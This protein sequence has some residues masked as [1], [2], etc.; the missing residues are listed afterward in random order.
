M[1]VF[2]VSLSSSSSSSPFSSSLSLS[3]DISLPR[4]IYFSSYSPVSIQQPPLPL[5][6]RQ[7][8]SPSSSSSISSL[9]PNRRTSSSLSPSSSS[10]SLSPSSSCR[11]LTSF[12]QN[13][14]QNVPTSSSSLCECVSPSHHPLPWISTEILRRK[15]K[16]KSS[17]ELSY[18]N[19]QEGEVKHSRKSSSSPCSLFSSLS[20]FTDNF[21]P[22]SSSSSSLW[23]TRVNPIK[24]HSPA[25]KFSNA[26]LS[27]TSFVSSSSSYSCSFSAL[28]SLAVSSSFPFPDRFFSP[29][30]L[31][32]SQN[33]CMG[34]VRTVGILASVTAGQ[35]TTREYEEAFLPRRLKRIKVF[36]TPP[37]RDLPA[38]FHKLLDKAHSNPRSI[39]KLYRKYIKID[40]HPDY[41]WLVRCFCQLANTFGFNSFWA[42]KDKQVVHSIPS[43]KFLVYD[44]IE[45]KHLIQASEVPRLLYALAAIEYRS[46]HLLPTLLEHV[47]ANLHRW[48][49]P[50]LC[51]MALSL[52][53]M[54]VGDNQT[55]EQR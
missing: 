33:W 13:V 17:R 14:F 9:K 31:H 8:V 52:A 21:S 53:L 32:A 48:R 44:L 29:P 24:L 19:F 27:S 43:F 37:P 41:S 5:P 34:G 30:S 12:S 23:Y 20:W 3:R 49:A 39:L 45:R 15:Q 1:K 26:S 2:F 50:T 4:R 40:D 46:W 7:V 55:G 36:N 6:R 47:D 10:S 51:N 25:V 35:M 16:K 22:L 18:F 11:L 28:S 42:T 38:H 54:G